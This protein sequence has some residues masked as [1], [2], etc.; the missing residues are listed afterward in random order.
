MDWMNLLQ[1]ILYAVITGAIGLLTTF[2]T[3]WIKQKM[4]QAK[5]TVKTEEGQKYLSMLEDT[6]INCVVAT[7]QTYVSNLKKENLFEF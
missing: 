3:L 2:A 1:G 6:V 7:N 5:N 4:S